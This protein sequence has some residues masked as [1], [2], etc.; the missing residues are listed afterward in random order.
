MKKKF[1]FLFFFNTLVLSS[2]QKQC[3][4]LWEGEKVLATESYAIKVP[5]LNEANYN[6]DPTD[7]LQFVAQWEINQAVDES[8]VRVS[9]VSYANMT[10]KELLDID[11]N[12]LP[13][14]LS[15][16]LKTSVSRDQMHAFF[17]LSPIIDRKSVV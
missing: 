17:I 3:Q 13:T 15:Y 16:Q 2:K 10:A 11:I 6:N 9:N 8:S 14:K 12:S 1:L 7:G 5:A 4:I